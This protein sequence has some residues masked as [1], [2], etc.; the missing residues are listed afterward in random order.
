MVLILLSPH[1]I[2]PPL[3]LSPFPFQQLDVFESIFVCVVLG[4]YFS[5]VTHI[6]FEMK[7]G[8]EERVRIDLMGIR[9]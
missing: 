6:L 9:R 2:P 3:F 7:E 5:V 4:R 8:S 1:T